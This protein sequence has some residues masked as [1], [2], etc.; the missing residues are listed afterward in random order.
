MA[1]DEQ[2][3]QGVLF[4]PEEA[5][6]TRHPD[7]ALSYWRIEMII[8]NLWF[9]AMTSATTW[10]IAILWQ[11]SSWWWMS[12]NTFWVLTGMWGWYRE[13]TGWRVAGYCLGTEQVW[14]RGGISSRFLQVAPYGRIQTCDVTTT[15]WSRKFNLASVRVN[16]GARSSLSISG[17]D[18][19]DAAR[20]R[21]LFTDLALKRGVQL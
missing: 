1:T 13:K 16:T 21:E 4:G 9:A 6:F 5:D 8:A 15:F 20:I 14:V 3:L 17:I 7:R 11:G 12:L 2:L 18:P 19:Q 10:L